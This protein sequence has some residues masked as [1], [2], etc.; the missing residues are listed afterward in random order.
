MYTNAYCTAF[1][2]SSHHT[3]RKKKEVL[4]K[5]SSRSSIQQILRERATLVFCL[6]SHDPYIVNVLSCFAK[7][8]VS[9]NNNNNL[10]FLLVFLPLLAVTITILSPQ[11]HAVCRNRTLD[12]CRVNDDCIDTQKCLGR[13]TDTNEIALCNKFIPECFCSPLTGY[14]S[15]TVNSDCPL[16][17]ACAKSSRTQNKICVG[18]QTIG[19]VKVRKFMPLKPKAAKIY[20][21][22]TPRRCA[23]TLDFCSPSIQ[24]GRGLYC[25]DIDRRGIVYECSKESSS[26]QCHRLNPKLT[27]VVQTSCKSQEDCSGREMCAMDLSRGQGFSTCTSCAVS[28]YNIMIAPVSGNGKKSKKCQRFKSSIPNYPPGANGLAYDKCDHDVQCLQPNRCVQFKVKASPK[29]GLKPCV[30]SSKN[31]CFCRRYAKP[32]TCRFTS[33]CRLGEACVDSPRVGV[34]KSCVSVAFL[35]INKRADYKL[36]G[37]TPPPQ[38]HSTTTTTTTAGGIGAAANGAYGDTCRFDWQCK[39]PRRCTHLADETYGECAGRAACKCK[40]LYPKLCTKHLE[41]DHPNELCVTYIDS[42]VASFCYSRSALKTSTTLISISLLSSLPKPMAAPTKPPGNG[43]TRDPCGVN[44]HCVAP[45]LCTHVTEGRYGQCNNRRGCMCKLPPP[46]QAS[47]R[48]M[49]SAECVAQEVCVRYKG[50]F[51]RNGE[52]TS[53]YVF[54]TDV[55][56]TKLLEQ[57][58]PRP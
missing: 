21:K 24:C 53:R 55:Q 47:N 37:N 19:D 17:E 9:S 22:K 14:S 58:S 8:M 7:T 35:A 27:N 49:K 2:R 50:A 48:C 46:K 31:L 29:S 57:V 44:A 36:Y 28:K 3:A 16:G 51:P 33:D 42:S 18:C 45:R 4:D 39:A 23:R 26:C 40:P 25:V 54:S 30:D 32:P 43:Y 6:P 56:T 41:C 11:V 15:C 38:R 13:T 52:C 12:N 5:T 10:S 34:T 20:C 1:P